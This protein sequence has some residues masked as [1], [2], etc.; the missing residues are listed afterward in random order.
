M[1]LRKDYLPLH[2]EQLFLEV[3]L[4]FQKGV[5]IRGLARAYIAQLQALEQ[6][7]VL[8]HLEGPLEPVE[9]CGLV[10]PDFLP[11]GFQL[12]IHPLESEQGVRNASDEVEIL[13]FPFRD[14]ERALGIHGRLRP[15]P[16]ASAGRELPPKGPGKT[17]LVF[18]QPIQHLT[19]RN[20]PDTG[21]E[22]PGSLCQIVAPCRLHLALEDIQLHTA[23]FQHVRT[24]I[25]AGHQLLKGNVHDLSL[26]DL[27]LGGTQDSRGLLPC[28]D[29]DVAGLQKSGTVPSAPFFSLRRRQQEPDLVRGD[30]KVR[31]HVFRRA[32]QGTPQEEA[33]LRLIR[34]QRGAQ[35]VPAL[36]DNRVGLYEKP[37][38]G[39]FRKRQLSRSIQGQG[40][41]KQ[42]EILH[43]DTFPFLVGLAADRELATRGLLKQVLVFDLHA[44]QVQASLE[45]ECLPGPGRLEVHGQGSLEAEFIRKGLRSRRYDRDQQV[46]PEPFAPD[47]SFPSWVGPEGLDHPLHLESLAVHGDLQRFEHEL[48]CGGLEDEILR[49]R[50][51]QRHRL[52]AAPLFRPGRLQ[53]KVLEIDRS[54]GD[55]LLI[56]RALCLPADT[57]R[58]RADPHGEFRGEEAHDGP[59]RKLAQGSPDVEGDRFRPHFFPHGPHRPG[60]F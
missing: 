57:P 17:V 36:Q 35:L 60:E 7:N 32:S 14:T 54:P 8:A 39:R 25:H 59:E 29:L 23:D 31:G 2:V 30:L 18:R 38:M 9:P 5:R 42:L 37:E 51:M 19:H 46:R 3:H 6:Q 16:G 33:P 56:E 11:T 27:R 41:E 49:D 26:L 4:S 50:A 48:L 52:R 53:P 13:E 47:L 12:L 44:L 43:R 28:L 21:P 40:V 55:D 45:I 1:T 15:C 58:S 22:T 24:V 34:C 10:L 20:V